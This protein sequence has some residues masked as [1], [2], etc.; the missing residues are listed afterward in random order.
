M[1]GSKND[2]LEV[3]IYALILTALLGWRLVAMEPRQQRG[4]CGHH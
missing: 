3:W 1:R 2:V 4:L